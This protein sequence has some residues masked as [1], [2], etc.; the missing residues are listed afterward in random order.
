MVDYPDVLRRTFDANYRIKAMEV[1]RLQ[2][3]ENFRTGQY[4]TLIDCAHN[5]KPDFQPYRKK[6]AVLNSS[7]EENRLIFLEQ[8]IL[9]F[10]PTH[11]KPRPR[12]LLCLP[13]ANP[14]LFRFNA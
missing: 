2:I 7:L 8:K 9:V 11:K 4:L 10:L 5:L 14:I 6:N 12:L 3:T 1:V 13:F